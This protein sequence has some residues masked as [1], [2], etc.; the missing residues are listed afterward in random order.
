MN[1][2]EVLERVPPNKGRGQRSFRARE[3]SS[4]SGENS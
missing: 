4:T 2:L 3:P 1:D